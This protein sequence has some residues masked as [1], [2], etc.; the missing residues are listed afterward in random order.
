VEDATTGAAGVLAA[1][2]AGAVLVDMST[3]PPAVTRAIA[4]AA[5][6]RGVS[7][8]DAPVSGGPSRA[9]SG[10]LSVMVGG[11]ADVVERARPLL[12]LLGERVIHVGET[13]AGQA[14]KMVNNV[15]TS[16]NL[17]GI[18]E[19]LTLGFRQGLSLQSMYD[20]ISDSSGGSRR[21]AD[22]VGRLLRGE[23][24]TSYGALDLLAKDLELALAAAAEHP[25]PMP[26]TALTREV[27]RLAQAKGLGGRDIE[28]V[29]EM[30]AELGDLDA[31]EVF[32]SGPPLPASDVA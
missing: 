15:L 17:V 14:M 31:A 22:S 32:R 19:A 27:Y 9:S 24:G 18:A 3:T 5:A 2:R 29:V 21:F 26:V 8:L 4:A 10:R 11:P 16:V 7:F 13:G 6:E 12:E 28:S 25:L 23:V 30:F 20:V 1:L